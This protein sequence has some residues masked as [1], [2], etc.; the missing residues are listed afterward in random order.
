MRKFFVSLVVLVVAAGVA[1][2]F[3]WVQFQLPAD[4]YGVIFTKTGGF[5]QEVVK[6]GAFVWRWQRLLPT[7]LTLFVFHLSAQ[8][9]RITSEG[10]LPSGTLYAQFLEGKPSFSYNITVDVSYVLNPDALPRLMMD[11]HVTPKNLDAWYASFSKR[12]STAIDS[13]IAAQAATSPR[14]A[15]GLNGL[16]PGMQKELEKHFPEVRFTSVAPRTV[17]MPDLTL[18]EK[19]REQYLAI[20]GAEEKARQTAAVTKTN[21]D[22]LAAQKIELL[23]KY[24]ELFNQYPVLLKFLDLA[25]AKRQNVIPGF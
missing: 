22:A 21:L 10:T 13:Y 5:E 23:R 12:L 3:G 14:A 19:A 24:G 1:F 9:D 20:M 8:E 6:P 2:Y 17:E 15:F 16:Q 18:Y 7:N 11:D 4:S 25:P